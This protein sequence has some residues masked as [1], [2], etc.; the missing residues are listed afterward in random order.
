MNVPSGAHLIGFVDDLA[1]VGEARNGQLLEY[2]I[3]TGLANIDLW[4]MS[5]GIGL[6][7]ILGDHVYKK[8]EVHPAQP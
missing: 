6:Q 1:V 8:V 5:H 2:L 3:N 4:M 7:K